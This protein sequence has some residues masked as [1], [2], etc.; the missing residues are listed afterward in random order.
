MAHILE[1]RR[2]GRRASEMLSLGRDTHSDSASPLFNQSEWLRVRYKVARP[3]A[4][5]VAEHCFGAAHG[6]ATR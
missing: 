3:F 4:R 6:R 1:T 5:V 2:L